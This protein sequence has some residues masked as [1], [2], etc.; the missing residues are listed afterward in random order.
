MKGLYSLNATAKVDFVS[1]EREDLS[2][3]RKGSG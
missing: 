1:S 3:N 2:E